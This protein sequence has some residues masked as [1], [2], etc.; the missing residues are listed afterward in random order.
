[1]GNDILLQP[2]QVLTEQ[3]EIQFTGRG[4]IH[5]PVEEWVECR[6]VKMYHSTIYGGAHGTGSTVD[7]ARLEAVLGMA[8]AIC[9]DVTAFDHDADEIFKAEQHRWFLGQIKEHQDNLDDD[10][11]LDTKTRKRDQRRIDVL[12]ELLGIWQE[13]HDYYPEE[14]SADSE[15]RIAQRAAEIRDH[16]IRRR[17]ASARIATLAATARDASTN[18]SQPAGCPD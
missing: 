17:A 2:G 9:D 10:E 6:I 12:E 16:T 15:T 4:R 8:R 18:I 7:E 11:D 13:D 5:R 14:A 1:M 3:W